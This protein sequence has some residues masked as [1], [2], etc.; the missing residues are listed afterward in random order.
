MK[1]TQLTLATALFSALSFGVANAANNQGVYVGAQINGVQQKIEYNSYDDNFSA[2]QKESKF[3]APGVVVGANV[4]D[5]VRAEVSYNYLNGMDSH[6]KHHQA[7]VAVIYDVTTGEGFNP[8]VG[9]KTDYNSVKF[10]GLDL[11][12]K[13]ASVAPL[14]G[15]QYNFSNGIYLDGRYAY[16]F[17]KKVTYEGELIDGKF[18]Y[19]TPQSQFTFGVGY[20]F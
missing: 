12:K 5:Q 3:G 6:L 4:A 14:V 7:G 9:V 2:S 17:G 13:Y 10:E 16:N 18:E 11:S 15:A 19:K 1:L 8:Y 20:K